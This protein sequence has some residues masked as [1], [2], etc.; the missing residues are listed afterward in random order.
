MKVWMG[1]SM[2]LTPVQTFVEWVEVDGIFPVS[3]SAGPDCGRELAPAPTADSQ[4]SLCNGPLQISPDGTRSN[5][6]LV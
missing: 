5:R 3:S 4:P 6:S 2:R 1:S